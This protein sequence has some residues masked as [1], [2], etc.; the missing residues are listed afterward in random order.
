MGCV[1]FETVLN[2]FV[3]TQVEMQ[4]IFSSLVQGIVIKE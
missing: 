4:N 3:S 2:N 1:C